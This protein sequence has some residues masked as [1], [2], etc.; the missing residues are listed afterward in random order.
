MKFAVVDALVIQGLTG[1]DLDPFSGFDG[2]IQNENVLLA[3]AKY[4]KHHQGLE[5]IY[6]G[7]LFSAFWA[8]NYTEA[9]RLL[10]LSLTIPSSKM[11]K[12]QLI[13][14]TFYRGL[15]AYQMH[16]NGD[17]EEHLDQ[18]KKVL[19]KME[20]WNQRASKAVFENKLYLLEAEHYASNCNIQAAKESYELSAKTARDHGLVHEQ[21]LAYELYGKFLTSIGEPDASHWFQQAYSCYVQ[22]GAVAK[23]EQ[24]R[25]DGKLGS[26]EEVTSTFNPSL[27]SIKHGR[28]EDEAEELI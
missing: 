16:R 17:G 27:V 9:N 6:T 23:A 25:K 24:L 10:E 12:I 14:H 2:M 1:F 26:P 28:D 3:N 22:W 5:S 11:P 20:L 21:G 15:I 7:R 4:K 13:Y 18:G 8:G 19:D